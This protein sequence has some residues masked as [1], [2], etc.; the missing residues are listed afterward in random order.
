MPTVHVRHPAVLLAGICTALLLPERAAAQPEDSVVI[1]KRVELFSEILGENRPLFIRTPYGYESGEEHYPVLYLLDGDAHFQHTAGTADYLA[2]S[3]RTPELIIVAIRNTDRNRDLTPPSAQQ[4]DIEDYP[5]HGGADNF[6]RFISDELMPW[7]NGQYRTRPHSTLVGHSFGGL[8]A[9][10][11]LVT[12]PDVFDAYVAISP[13]LQWDDQRL[14]TQAAR[15][16]ENTPE[17]TADLYM[18]VGNEGRALLGGA[19]KLAGVLDE[20]APRGLRWAFRLMEEESHVSVALRS[21]WQG[22][23]AVFDGWNLHDVLTTFDRGGLAAIDDHYTRGGARFGYDRATPASAVL[24]LVFQLIQADRLEEAASVLLRDTETHP[25][26]SIALAELADA[27]ADRNDRASAREYYT[28]ALRA[29]AG[30][31]R[32][33][34]KLLDMGVDVSA[35]VPDFMV[36]PAAL[37]DY[38]G[39]YRFRGGFVFTIRKVQDATLEMQVTGLADTTLVPLSADV[40]S[41]ENTDD[42]LTFNRDA[43]GEVESLIWHQF[44]GAVPASKIE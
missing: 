16:F 4:S 7:V 27:Y 17:L 15:M 35:L 43:G 36:A 12:R 22:L 34:R 13:G 28:L 40:F 19:R 42:Q 23:E 8:F 33:R 37:A 10:H 5:T 18:T 3:G 29:N 2:Y 1:G 25:P 26:S 32:A 38:V 9:L 24:T 6:L 14:V 39:R 41:L 11:A 44:E 31:E 30:N 21:T 20:H